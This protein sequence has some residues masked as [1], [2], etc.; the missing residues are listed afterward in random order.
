MREIF[1]QTFQRD[2]HGGGSGDGLQREKVSHTLFEETKARW[3]EGGEM[4]SDARSHREKASQTLVEEREAQGVRG[5]K[6]RK[7]V[8]NPLF[9]NGEAQGEGEWDQRPVN[10]ESSVSVLERKLRRHLFIGIYKLTLRRPREF[11]R[12]SILEGCFTAPEESVDRIVQ[13]QWYRL[14]D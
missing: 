13:L 3:G 1:A 6:Q 5:R 9:E 14:N 4:G 12:P 10:I 2:I 8:S 7:Q 11:G